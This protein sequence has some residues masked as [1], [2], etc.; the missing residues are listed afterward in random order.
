M[1]VQPSTPQRTIIRYWLDWL[2]PRSTNRD[3]AFREATIRITVSLF[4]A[5]LFLGLIATTVVF[6]N[7]WDLISWPSMISTMLILAIL[8]ALSVV[9]RS[10]LQAGWLL[11]ATVLFGAVGVIALSNYA[12]PVVLPTLMLTV[13][14]SA[15]LL[16][17][18]LIVPV[19]IVCSIILAVLGGIQTYNGL[20][21]SQDQSLTVISVNAFIVLLSEGAFLWQLRREFDGRLSAMSSALHEAEMSRREADQANQAKSQ[22]LANMSHELRTPLNAVIGYAEIMIGGMAGAFADKQLQLVGHIHQNAKR[23]LDLI[24]GILDLARVEAGRVEIIATPNLPR[25]LV[26]GLVENMQSIAQKKK[27][28]LRATFNE[29]MPEVVVCDAGKV[30]Q[31]AT[32]LIGNAL[33]FTKEGEVEVI[34]GS[35]EEQTWHIKVRDTGSGMPPDKVNSIFEMFSQLDNADTRE[36]EG[37]GLGLAITKRLV[38]RMG[39]TIAVET[40]LGAGSTFTV[41]LPRL[42]LPVEKTAEAKPAANLEAQA[43]PVGPENATLPADKSQEMTAANKK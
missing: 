14:V 34:V 42:L 8:S 21:L 13:V 10:I 43:V 29:N 33:K 24:N 31:V 7:P 37:T 4:G 30:Q 15:L 40:R 18:H 22:F 20:Q 38:E 39:G 6:Q 23:L 11:I 19:G 26:G 32:N 17:R 1:S 3:E 28:I 25:K 27:L 5:L 12:N 35:S 9:R 16:P 36:H 41:T 2:K